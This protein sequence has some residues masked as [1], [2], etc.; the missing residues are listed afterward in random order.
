MVELASAWGGMTSLVE[1][2]AQVRR[3][4][5]YLVDGD[6]VY[7]HTVRDRS[8]EYQGVTLRRGSIAE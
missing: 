1:L 4:Q 3:E 2:E 5:Q 7:L 8:N 6:K